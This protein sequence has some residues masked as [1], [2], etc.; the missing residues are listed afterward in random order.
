LAKQGSS[1]ISFSLPH[2]HVGANKEGGNKNI[3][4]VS[5]AEV[6]GFFYLDYFISFI[7]F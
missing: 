4:C 2:H 1:G 6:L 5:D 3:Y 7:L